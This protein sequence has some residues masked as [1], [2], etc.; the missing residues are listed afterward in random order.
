MSVVNM[1]GQTKQK[2]KLKIA[3]C[4]S[5]GSGKS[6]AS[7]KIADDP[8]M[9]NNCKVLSL[10][11]PIK[12]I[13]ANMNQ[14]SRA[15]HIMIGSAGRAIDPD[16]WVKK[17]LDKVQECSY[18]DIVVDD[19]RFLNEAKALRSAGFKI[20]RLKTPWHVRFKR[21][22][23]RCGDNYDDLQHFND[24]SEIACEDIPESI[25]DEIWETPTEIDD[26]IK[27]VL[28]SI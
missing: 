22:K 21:I 3:F 8:K 4:G 13:A 16:V 2:N 9:E 26:G 28:E 27:T 1:K 14:S 23:L 24:P 15:A 25:F 6:Y 5:M 12:E 19:V 18:Y 11:T 17:L 7:R 10:A 20:I